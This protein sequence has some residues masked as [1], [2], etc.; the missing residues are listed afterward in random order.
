M[1]MVA[2]IDV[3]AAL[4]SDISDINSSGYGIVFFLL[5]RNALCG[6]DHDEDVLALLWLF[7]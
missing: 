2:S 4:W 7:T 5:C 6:S 3:N 1:L